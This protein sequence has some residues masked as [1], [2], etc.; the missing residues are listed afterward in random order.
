MTITS[1]QWNQIRQA[2]VDNDPEQFQHLVENLVADGVRQL[3]CRLTA[4]R[5]A[6]F[7]NGRPFLAC[8]RPE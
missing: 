4:R 7:I 3:G 8:E 6:G 1:E 5:Q 2:V